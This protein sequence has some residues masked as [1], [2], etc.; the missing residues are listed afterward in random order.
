[1][2]AP[3]FWR[4]DNAVS[5]LLSPLGSVYGWVVRHRLE[6]AEEYRPAIPVICVG[7]IVA[8]GAGKTPVG[9]ALA[10]RLITAGVKPHFLTRGYGGTEVGPRAVDLDRHDFARV[11]DEALLLA[12]EAPTWVAR[13]RPDGA[14]AAAEMGAEVIIMDDGFQNGSIAKD[15]SLV[16]VDGSYGF[17]NGRTMPAG[18]CR[19]PP[20]QGLAR[21][22]AMVVIGKDRRGLAELARAH[23][24]PLLA[25]R[26]VPGAEGA[27]LKGR[28]VVAF[29]GIGR[30]EK[31]FASLKQCGARLTADHSFPDHHPFARADI[32]A[33]LAE[34]ESNEAL[35][36][37]T[38]KDRVRL[39]ADLRARVSVLSVSL[40]W[41]DP[42]LLTP[43]FDRIGVRA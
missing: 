20:D 32:E 43:L 25:A 1:M 18:P 4:R 8:G 23:D 5:R 38:A 27:E 26:L 31:F 41:E 30:P 10:R 15:L 16:V 13:W 19:E 9:I 21:A 39:P 40:D 37:T 36:V 17:G 12:R 22:D 14:V 24:I 6:R 3:D 33:L 34:A 35:L 11:G 42:S 28:K 7:N 29:A 2:R